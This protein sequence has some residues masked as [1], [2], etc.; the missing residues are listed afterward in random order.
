MDESGSK[1]EVVGAVLGILAVFFVIILFLTF[2][3][4]GS[5][6]VAVAER[7]GDVL[8]ERSPGIHF[9][10]FTKYSKYDTKLQTHQSTQ[11][12]ATSDLQDINIDVT[13]SYKIRPDKV[14]EIYR[15]IGNMDD[16]KV[17]ALDPVIAQTL[18]SITTQFG[19][20]EL[21]QKRNEVGDLIQKELTEKLETGYSLEVTDVSLTNMT[22]TNA[23]FN[24]AIDRKQIA[25]QD[26]LRAKFELERSKIEAEKSKA[27]QES[28]TPE[29]LQKMWLEKWDGKLPM[30]TGSNI[31][32]Y[33]PIK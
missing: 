17:K 2:H 30:Y 27:Q 16:V 9:D 10:F 1:G 19:G 24:A 11:S 25:E 22:F 4:V 18:K 15:T 23:E 12:A 8:G 6:Q 32:L 14:T 29:I 26:S 31:P 7:F 28:L 33:M 5:T 21:I 13:V 3:Q 20:E